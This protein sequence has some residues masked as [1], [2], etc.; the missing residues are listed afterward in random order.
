VDSIATWYDLK[1]HSF[2]HS[3][4]RAREGEMNFFFNFFL[5][6]FFKKKKKKKKKRASGCSANSNPALIKKTF[7][8]P[9]R[10]SKYSLALGVRIVKEMR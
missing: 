1:H 4:E 8:F 6:F 2:R 9:G 3:P 7:F 5:N 10:I